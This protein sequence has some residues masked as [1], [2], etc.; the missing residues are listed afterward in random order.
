MHRI[1]TTS[2]ILASVACAWIGQA[3]AGEAE[4]KC[5]QSG[6]NAL[7]F[8]AG[9]VDGQLGN[10]TKAAFFKFR[11]STEGAPNYN[12]VETTMMEWCL[13]IANREGIDDA[14][15]ALA[16][17][18]EEATDVVVRMEMDPLSFGVVALAS[19]DAILAQSNAF[20]TVVENDATILVTTFPYTDV[21]NATR[22]CVKLSPEYRV[23][24]SNGQA[25][26]GACISES[27][28]FWLG[29]R[30][31]PIPTARADTL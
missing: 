29:D 9:T 8:Q 18:L 6:L 1:T 31:W 14:T 21:R 22:I 4:V 20:E 19:S 26:E 25:S 11:D 15:R 7:G 27:V 30:Q 10:G 28:A 16:S 24:N 12:I 23:V 3:S 13:Y 17:P 2:A 5:I